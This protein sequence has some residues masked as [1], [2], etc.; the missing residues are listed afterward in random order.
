MPIVRIVD[1]KQ[2]GGEL[3]LNIFQKFWRYE[4]NQRRITAKGIKECKIENNFSWIPEIQPVVSRIQ[5]VVFISN[6]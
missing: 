1:L 2:D 3:F 4:E 6:M 5:P